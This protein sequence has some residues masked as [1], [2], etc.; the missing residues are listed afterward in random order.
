MVVNLCI[1][2]KPTQL[3][4]AW[5]IAL[6]AMAVETVSD[7]FI[8]YCFLYAGASINQRCQVSYMY[9]NFYNHV[10]VLLMLIVCKIHVDVYALSFL[11]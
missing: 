11:A 8:Y 1:N 9:T 5:S 10:Y 2:V 4:S 7:L 3:Q 6:S